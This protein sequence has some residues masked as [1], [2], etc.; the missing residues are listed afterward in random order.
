M[1]Q[2]NNIDRLYHIRVIYLQGFQQQNMLPSKYEYQKGFKL[3]IL[4]YK[5]D[6]LLENIFCVITLSALTYNDFN[7]ENNILRT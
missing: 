1:K 2:A 7:L 5:Q 4:L 6:L 3:P